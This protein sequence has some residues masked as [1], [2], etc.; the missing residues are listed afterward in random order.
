MQYNKEEYYY[1]CAA[2]KNIFNK[3]TKSKNSKSNFKS[4]VHI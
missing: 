3:K 2:G 1:I 4:I